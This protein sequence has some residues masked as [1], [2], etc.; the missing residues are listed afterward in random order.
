MSP[1]VRP[2][3]AKR[4]RENA[5]KEKK[6]EKAERRARKL[7]ERQDR[8]DGAPEEDPDLAG[9]VAGPQPIPEEDE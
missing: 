2:T 7:A 8:P 1:R 6:S 9:I 5:K 4:Q 3:F